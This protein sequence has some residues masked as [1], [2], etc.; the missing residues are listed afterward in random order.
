MHLGA[1]IIAATCNV[2][3]LYVWQLETLPKWEF[4][5]SQTFFG[6][7]TYSLSFFNCDRSS[8]NH[9]TALCSYCVGMLLSNKE[10]KTEASDG[11]VLSLMDL[12]HTPCIVCYYTELTVASLVKF[13]GVNLWYGIHIM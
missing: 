4:I 13:L 1:F 8:S 6:Q 10:E 2:I 3:L 7:P 9:S 5:L 11:I 12:F